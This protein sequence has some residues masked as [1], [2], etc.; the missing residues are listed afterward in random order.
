M[1]NQKNNPDLIRL[2]DA[3]SEIL[4]VVTG[5]AQWTQDSSLK[6]T[7]MRAARALLD[8]TAAPDINFRTFETSMSDGSGSIV[9]VQNG[10]VVHSL[11]EHHLLPFYGTACVAILPD[12]TK[13]RIVGLS[14]LARIVKHFA[15]GLN[16]QERI[17]SRAG[18]FLMSSVLN[19][20]AVGVSLKCVHMCMCMRGVRDPQASTLTHFLGGHARTDS[21]LRAEIL[22]AM[23]HPSD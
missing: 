4:N 10:I 5:S 13:R 6:D 2:R 9:V 8:L 7:P 23:K 3:Y 14:K 20:V 19:P 15:A 12:P 18:E 21:A 22:S 16:T 17:T 11:C 1:G